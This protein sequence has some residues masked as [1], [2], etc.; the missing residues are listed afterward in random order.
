MN[1]KSNKSKQYKY[2]FIYLTKNLVNNKS[3]VGFHATNDLD[4]GYLG[5]G[6]ILKKS[7]SKHGRTNFTQEILEHCTKDNWEEK[8]RFWIKEKNTFSKTGYNL[9]NGGEGSLGLVFSKKSRKKLSDSKKGKPTWNKGKNNIY[10]EETLIKM[11]NSQ[12]NK[13]SKNPMYG[14]R[15][16]D[17]PIYGTKQTKAH[18]QKISESRIGLIYNKIE[19]P[20]C[21]SLVDPGNFKRW[22]G[23]KCKSLKLTT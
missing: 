3:Y 4:D 14:K 23:D 17:S 19:C 18:R 11:S 1:N 2:Y 8:E 7:I 12:D 21:N 20:Y 13:G 22:H 6:V 16:E 9:T 5:S 10:S 15:G